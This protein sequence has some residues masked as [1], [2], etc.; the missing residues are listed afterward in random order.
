M[1]ILNL[2]SYQDMFQTP[3]FANHHL[4]RT[5]TDPFL[6]TADADV[7][8]EDSTA[9]TFCLLKS[10]SGVKM[11]GGDFFIPARGSRDHFLLSHPL[12]YVLY[13]SFPVTCLQ[14]SDPMR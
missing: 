13:S 9:W 12:S 1:C 5:L 8:P 2:C 10:G 4:C 3:W 14:V 7:D 11:R 6:E